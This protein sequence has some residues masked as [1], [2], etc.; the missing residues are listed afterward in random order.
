MAGAEVINGDH[1]PHLMQR[2]EQAAGGLGG[3]DQFPLGQLQHQG[4]LAGWERG[5]EFP[6]VLHQRHVLAMARCDVHADMKARA[7]ACG[8]G[9][10][11]HGGLA[12]QGTGHRHD[13]A[14]VFG[15]GNKQ[16][17]AHQAFFGMLP[18]HQDLTAGPL[19]CVTPYHRLE[20]RD[21]LI[22]SQG[23]L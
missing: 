21:E 2:L 18:A 17:R 19:A 13:Q 4:D 16:V 9:R 15:Q 8:M 23:A 12:Q 5:E 3:F 1:D 22:G 6:A 7:E 14:R 20:I 10:Q 11:L